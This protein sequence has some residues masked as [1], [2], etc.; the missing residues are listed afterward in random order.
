MELGSGAAVA[1]GPAFLRRAAGAEEAKTYVR[2]H[3]SP[4]LFATLRKLLMECR[5]EVVT[6][7]YLFTFSDL[8]EL[9]LELLAR[10]VVISILVNKDDDS[11]S[12]RAMKNAA[13]MLKLKDAGANIRALRP[14]DYR[15]VE[16]AILHA[17]TWLID[18]EVLLISTAN[19][20]PTGLLH[21]EELIIETND[22][23]A[24]AD[25]SEWYKQIEQYALPN[26]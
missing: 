8:I 9:L 24:V 17:K 18:G 1:P 2:L 4:H 16:H 22:V 12:D 21:S 25:Y 15:K 20:T 19:A 7:Q 26:L 13:Q 11:S 6:T 3:K 14:K 10:G 23:Q 5:H